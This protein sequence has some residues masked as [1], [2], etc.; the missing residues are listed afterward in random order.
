VRLTFLGVR[1]STPASGPGFER[2]GGHTSCVAISDGD[3]LPSLVLDA[4]TGLQS[5]T[6]RFGSSPFVGTILLTH[7]H[8]DHVQGLP[9]FPPADRDDARV[10]LVQPAQGDPVAVLSRSMSPPH[11]PIGPEGLRGTWSFVGLESGKHTIEGFEVLARDVVHK[12][13]RTFGYRV[14]AGDATFAYVP[15]ALDDNDDVIAELATDV[16]LFVRG[17]PFVTDESERAAL[18]GHGTAEHAV[19]IARR[20]GANRLLLTHHG[21][22]RTDDGVDAIAQRLNVEAAYEGLAI[23]L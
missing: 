15:D 9:F 19:E 7:L 13:G 4:G 5:L 16:D 20:A 10:T 21:P 18:F 17:A 11:F 1:G 14:R 23:D 3:A 12:G 22:Y 2:V 6:T 8:W